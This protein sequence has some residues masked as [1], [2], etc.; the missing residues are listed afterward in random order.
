LRQ[1]LPA[2]ISAGQ[3][4]RVALARTLV[5]DPVVLLLDEPLS[6][7]DQLLRAK[8]RCELCEMFAKLNIPTLLVTHDPEDAKELADRIL[9]VEQ[10]RIRQ[11]ASYANLE[12]GASS[13]RATES[14]N[15]PW[16]ESPD[17]KAGRFAEPD[18]RMAGV[19]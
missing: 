5:L 16:F 17:R 6:A 13:R 11:V 3:R 9:V 4:Q 1:A 7:L 12:G 10:G 15:M 19:H 8:V 2:N 14:P 18:A